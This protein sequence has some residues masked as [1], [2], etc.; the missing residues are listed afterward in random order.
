MLHKQRT[1]SRRLG[2]SL[3]EL[4]VVVAIITVL[5][6]LGTWAYFAMIGNRQSRNTEATMKVVNK[7][8]FDRWTVVQVAVDFDGAEAV[9]AAVRVGA[10][11][12]HLRAGVVDL[13]GVAEWVGALV[14]ADQI[15]E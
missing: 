15:V 12:L 1:K 6:G 10:E 11:A 13:G 8:M 2:F 4:L 5:A 9:G 7:L 3:V 14:D